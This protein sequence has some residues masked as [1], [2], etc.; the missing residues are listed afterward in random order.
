MLSLTK[1]HDARKNEALLVQITGKQLN[2]GENLLETEQLFQNCLA[3]KPVPV[4]A[5][6]H[7]GAPFSLSKKIGEILFLPL[8][9][10]A[11]ISNPS[12]IHV[13]SNKNVYPDWKDTLDQEYSQLKKL[14]TK[15][16]NVVDF[17]A[18]GDGKTDCTKAFKKAIGTGRVKVIVPEGVFITK[19]L[20]LPSWTWLTG[21]GKGSTT[22]KLHYQADRSSRL[23]TNAHHWHGN[24]H[25]MIEG[26]RLD[27]NVE[28]LGSESK[29]STWGNHSS[30][31]TFANVTYGWIKDIEAVNPGLHCIDITSTLYNY[32]GDGR[33]G[34]G[35]SK[36]VW[37]DNVNGYGFGDDGI[38]THHS[39]YILISR[40]HLCDPSGRAHRK[41]YS[42][43]NGIE[44][45]DG[46]QNVVL[47][48]NSTARCFG[49]VEIKAHQNSSAASNVQIIGHISVNDNRSYNFRHIGHHKMEDPESKTAFN[50]MATNL[51]SIEPVFTD[52]YKDSK[53]RGLVISGYKNVVINHCTFIGNLDYD[54]RGGPVAAIQYRAR[55]VVLTNI[56]FKN[57]STAGSGIKIFGG[58]NR[59]DSIIIQNVEVTCPTSSSF[60]PIMPGSDLKDQKIKNVKQIREPGL[61]KS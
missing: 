28:R 2:I 33:R 34:R 12:N 24:H 20:R 35:G 55:N 6:N 50:I 46:S 51:V 57:F 29:T 5:A 17:G 7:K 14:I 25:I 37:V 48:N 43:S 31:L 3:K 19:G 52:L 42:N 44:I 41:G 16:V 13:D 8:S 15:E 60:E 10:P 4:P 11:F 1:S 21:A 36:Y 9:K 30:C 61:P 59:A 40:S 56:S 27:W 47:V 22:I 53:P 49:G 45:D 58:K 18:V 54:Y 23:I 32:A 38:T 39:D 26:L